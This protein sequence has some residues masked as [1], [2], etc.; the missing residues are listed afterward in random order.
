MSTRNMAPR[1]NEEGEI[2]VVGKVWKALR[3]KIIEATSKMTAPTVEATSKMTAPTVEAGDKSKNVATTEFVKNRENMVVSPFLLQ[4]NTAYKIGDMV[5]VPKLGEQYVLECTQAGTTGNTEPDLST[6]SG[7]VNDGTVKWT[8]KTVTAKEYIDE[9]I[10]DCEP[11]QKI[12]NINITIIDH[13]TLSRIECMKIGKVVMMIMKI[14]KATDGRIYTIAAGVP[15]MLLPH[16]F[17][18]VSLKGN[19]IRLGIKDKNLNIHYSNNY[20]STSGDECEAIITYLTS[21]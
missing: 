17:S 16:T 10:R 19:V 9:K 6:V 11:K 14:E 12:E 20:T 3:A 15:N 4:R 21:D 2:G 7:G 13:Q 18:V 8:V 1:A 5:K